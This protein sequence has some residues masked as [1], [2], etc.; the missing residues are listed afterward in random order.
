MKPPRRRKARRNHSPSLFLSSS[1]R[2][3]RLAAAPP[4]GA[5]G[6]SCPLPNQRSRTHTRAHKRHSQATRRSLRRL[7]FMATQQR[8]GAG[9]A[10]RQRGNLS[11]SRKRCQRHREHIKGH[12]IEPA[13]NIRGKP[14]IPPQLQS[15][16]QGKN[17]P[18][19]I[20]ELISTGQKNR[21]Q[22]EVTGGE[23]TGHSTHKPPSEAAYQ[24]QGQ[25][26][27][28]ETREQHLST[29]SASQTPQ[30][31]GSNNFGSIASQATLPS[32]Q[33]HGVCN[34]TSAPESHKPNMPSPSLKASGID[35]AESQKT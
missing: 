35:S 13:Q 19:D 28:C 22:V 17:A 24:G 8:T 2:R 29:S 6:D 18:I 33:S 30:N 31:G 34:G 16:I 27:F 32:R 26:T 23:S 21:H 1:V 7:F 15:E 10:T 12:E 5:C 4:A 14:P 20:G 9:Q 3:S 25:G 11:A